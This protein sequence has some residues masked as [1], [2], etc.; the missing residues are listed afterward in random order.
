MVPVPLQGTSISLV[1]IPRAALA[2]RELALG[3]YPSALQA[4]YDREDGIGIQRGTPDWSQ[5][6][7]NGDNSC[8]HLEGVHTQGNSVGGDAI[9]F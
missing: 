9:L 4:G 6:E 2:R 1:S 3:W 8:T 5:E 7:R